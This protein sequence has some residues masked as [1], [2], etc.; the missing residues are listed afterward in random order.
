MYTNIML[1]EAFS[2]NKI[3]SK[4]ILRIFISFIIT[5]K[6]FAFHK[7]IFWWKYRLGKIL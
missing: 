1:F 5:E 6:S 2:S 4:K 3:K 7:S